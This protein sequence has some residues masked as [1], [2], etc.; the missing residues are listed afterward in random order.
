MKRLIVSKGPRAGQFQ[1][2]SDD[3]LQ[4]N[5]ELLNV[6]YPRDSE[7]RFVRALKDRCDELFGDS[8]SG[9]ESHY[10]RYYSP[11]NS[12]RVSRRSMEALISCLF[13]DNPQLEKL[14][15][16][17]QREKRETVQALMQDEYTSAS[18]PSQRR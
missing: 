12:V 7:W 3:E 18:K 1:I 8:I 14:A 11:W 9:D 5:V 4:A 10:V 16:D 2:Y 6:F 13:N 15:K 17:F